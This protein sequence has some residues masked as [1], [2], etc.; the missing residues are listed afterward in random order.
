MK[1]IKCIKG[2][3]VQRDS[4]NKVHINQTCYS[5]GFAIFVG[6]FTQTC[7]VRADFECKMSLKEKWEGPRIRRYSE[8]HGFIQLYTLN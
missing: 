1:L 3:K 7:G 6:G 8:I 2:E 5:L 4:R